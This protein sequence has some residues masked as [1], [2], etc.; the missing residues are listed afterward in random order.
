[1]PGRRESGA[2]HDMLGVKHA[3]SLLIQQPTILSRVGHLMSWTWH[4]QQLYLLSHTHCPWLYFNFSVLIWTPYGEFWKESLSWN[5]Y[6]LGTTYYRY[7]WQTLQ[8]C[9]TGTCVET[10][11]GHV[12]PVPL[13][14]GRNFPA[15][16]RQI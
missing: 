14:W 1:M 15:V 4:M 6:C 16:W 7:F 2:V 5:C 9:K 13:S 12:T 8:Q 10:Q 11:A 3:I